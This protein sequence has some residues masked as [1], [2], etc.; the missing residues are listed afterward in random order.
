MKKIILFLFLLLPSLVFSQK[1]LNFIR[2]KEIE[3]GVLSFKVKNYN[4]YI[5]VLYLKEKKKNTFVLTL[6]TFFKEKEIQDIEITTFKSKENLNFDFYIDNANAYLVYQTPDNT[7][8]YEKIDSIYSKPFFAYKKELNQDQSQVY[9]LPSIYKFGSKIYVFYHKESVKNKLDILLQVSENGTDFNHPLNFTESLG[10]A[11]Y[12]KLFVFNSQLGIIF[13]GRSGEISGKIY[14]ELYLAKIDSLGTRIIDINKL[15]ENIGDNFA[16]D[17]SLTDGRILMSWENRLNNWRIMYNYLSL[18]EIKLLTSPKILTSNYYNYHAPKLVRFLDELYLF[19]QRIGSNSD[20][21]YYFKINSKGEIQEEKETRIELKENFVISASSCWLFYLDTKNRILRASA[22]TDT[23]EII[24][25]P[26][27]Q[28]KEFFGRNNVKIEWL[29]IKDESGIEGYYYLFDRTPYSIPDEVNKLDSS[30]S[31]INLYAPQ[32][33]VWYFHLFY[34]DKAGNKS[35]VL[36]KKIQVDTTIPYV[37]KIDFSANEI[38]DSEKN[39]LANTN[40]IKIKWN[41]N[42]NVEY[43]QYIVDVYPKFYEHKIKKTEETELQIPTLKAGKYYFHIHPVSRSGNKGEVITVPFIVQ[44]YAPSNT[45]QFTNYNNNEPIIKKIIIKQLVVKNIN[46][47]PIPSYLSAGENQ[48]FTIPF[49]DLPVRIKL[50]LIVSLALVFLIVV[51]LYIL[52]FMRHQKL[53]SLYRHIHAL[54]HDHLSF[55]DMLDQNI[56]EFQIEEGSGDEFLENLDMETLKKYQTLIDKAKNFDLSVQHLEEEIKHKNLSAAKK[57][58]EKTYE[59]A[60]LEEVI[61]EA[62]E[63]ITDAEIILEPKAITEAEVISEAE[64]ISEAEDISEAEVIENKEINTNLTDNIQPEE[65]EKT[66]KP[67]QKIKQEAPQTEFKEKLKLKIKYSFLITI[68]VMF[69]MGIGSFINGIITLKNT[70]SNLSN[71]IMKRAETVIK[72]LSNSMIEPA[73]VDDFLLIVE[74][75]NNYKLVEDIL[76]T[77]SEIVLKKDGKLKVSFKDTEDVFYIKDNL[78]NLDEI[79]EIEIVKKLIQMTNESKKPVLLIDP[80]VDTENLLKKYSLYYPVLY[81]KDKNYDMTEND[82]GTK[83]LGYTKIEFSTEKI[84][85]VIEEQKNEIFKIT[86]IIAIIMIAFGVVGAVFLSYLTVKPITNL[87]SGV[88]IVGEGNLE[89][90]IPIKTHD[91]IGRLTFEFNKMTYQLLQAQDEL[92]KKKVLEEQFSIAEGIQRSL[93]PTTKL[94]L[95]ELEISGFYK[96]ALGVGGD[97]FD[98]FEIDKDRVGGILSDVAGKGIPAALMMVNI[99]T[100]FRTNIK[101]P[102][103][104]PKEIINILN[105]VLAEDLANDMFA[106]LFFYI[107]NKKTKEI[108]FCNAGH[109]PLTYYCAKEKKVKTVISRTMPLGVMPNNTQYTNQNTKLESGDI[110]ILFTDGISE[111]MN[112]VRE[113]YSEERLFRMLEK[114]QSKDVEEINKNIISDLDDFVGEAP[115]HDDISFITMKIK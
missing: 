26:Y 19:V 86:I 113:E 33:G 18:N 93:I 82:I 40:N 95:K 100:V 30:T 91:E 110:V 65:K 21:L 63:I 27:L 22:D 87:V 111:A 109:G 23:A 85:K 61:H 71:E 17:L 54:S 9:S 12:P 32:E 31:F 66:K 24:L 69:T 73:L 2:H 108:I 59:T 107:Y 84:F 75:I 50:K 11:V 58:H 10:Y 49:W 16:A 8:F 29:P 53:F 5:G 34:Q 104:T 64:I 38:I 6:K 76:Y 115:Q 25:P 60:I 102:N 99:R 92:I 90:Q 96:A 3:N 72:S 68:L 105:N 41:K 88:K 77:S 46:L 74:Y 39:I 106:T 42:E 103:I 62:D 70:R 98:Y 35:Q 44:K 15:T 80:P 43:Y 1:E 97:Y 57:I 83:F 14:F 79:K 94:I 28:E 55:H 36:H 37:G 47:I 45:L 4:N 7:I 51:L 56:P 101:R 48:F 89:H 112:T 52:L 78:N 67:V 114:N 13:Q 81:S 20:S